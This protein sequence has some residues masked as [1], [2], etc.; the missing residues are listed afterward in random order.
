MV[1]AMLKTQSKLFWALEVLALAAV[2]LFLD[3]DPVRAAEGEGA[4]ASENA[5]AL[6]DGDY[7]IVVVRK[8]IV[9]SKDVSR[10]DLRR[11]FLSID[12]E[13]GDVRVMPFNLADPMRREMFLT[14]LTGY[15]LRR[16]EDHFVALG[17]SGDG[18]WPRE[19]ESALAMARAMA[20]NRSVK[21][22]AWMHVEDWRAIPKRYREVVFDVL[23]IEG[24]GPSAAD[25]P[26]KQN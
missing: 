17:L 2:M 25:Y 14:K 6:P 21:F 1:I 12:D 23:T 26:L 19:I 5:D 16:I 3:A 11:V 10:Q 15:S 24:N 7:F 18:S 9:P 22:V 13:L 20:T 8:G 4:A